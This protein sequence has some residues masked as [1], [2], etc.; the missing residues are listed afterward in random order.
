[1]PPRPFVPIA[2]VDAYV[3]SLKREGFYSDLQIADIRKKHQDALDAL[4]DAKAQRERERILRM[5]TKV[6]TKLSQIVT[7]A[8]D[9]TVDNVWE[10]N[11]KLKVRKDG[12]IKV[13]T[14]FP[15]A[16]FDHWMTHK[17]EQKP[18][19]MTMV[20]CMMLAGASRR[21]CEQIATHWV[22]SS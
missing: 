9:L 8:V 18:P 7:D 17:S 3:A 22:Q 4:R 20:K 21:A 14:V 15:F 13:D 1:M 19:M 2:D 16:E 12:S 10:C 11:V 6:L 5:E